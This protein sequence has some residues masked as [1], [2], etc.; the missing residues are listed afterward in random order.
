MSIH[1]ACYNEPPEMVIL[2]LDSLAALDYENFE[3]LVIDNNTKDEEVWK[4]V[5]EHCE[6]LGT[7]FRFFHLDPWPGFKAG[8]LNFGLEANRPARRHGRGRSTPTTRCGAT[9]WPR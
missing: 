2:T 7:R 5:E 9:G 1:L 8:A 3:V 4:P 6:K